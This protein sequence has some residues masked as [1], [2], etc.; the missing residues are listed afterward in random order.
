MLSM[1]GK[2]IFDKTEHRSSTKVKGPIMHSVL[3]PFESILFD[4]KKT[5]MSTNRNLF[6]KIPFNGKDKKAILTKVL[7]AT[8]LQPKLYENQH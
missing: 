8:L 2:V 4:Y 3:N 1:K 5:G 6:T 7:L